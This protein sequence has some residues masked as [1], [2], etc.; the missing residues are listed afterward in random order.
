MIF[1]DQ[2]TTRYE[3]Q[4]E[5]VEH[6][7]LHTLKDKHDINLSKKELYQVMS[8]MYEWRVVD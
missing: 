4:L 8:V 7:I 6:L 5:N 2:P 3:R 1:Y